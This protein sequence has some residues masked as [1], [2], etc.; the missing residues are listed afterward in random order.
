MDRNIHDI[1]DVILKIIA[2]V[3]GTIFLNYVGIQEEIDEILN[4]E[5]TTIKGNKL[6]LDFL[7][8]LK[9][10]TLLH[11]E[12]QYPNADDNCSD[13]FFKYNITAEVRHEGLTETLIFNFTRRIKEAKP[14]KR[15]H[16]KSFTPYQF[17]WGMLI[18][19]LTCKTLK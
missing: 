8:R 1:F 18:L 11:I 14:Q 10:G 17:I 15:G 4:V 7:C 9:N 2:V 12:F 13:R 3:Y 5:F 6:Y 16:S 19:K